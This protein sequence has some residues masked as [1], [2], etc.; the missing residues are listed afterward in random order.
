MNLS[1]FAKLLKKFYYNKNKEKEHIMH[2]SDFFKHFSTLPVMPMTSKYEITVGGAGGL[3]PYLLGI[4]KVI[5]DN[6]A[7]ELSESVIIGTSAGSLLA[8]LLSMGIPVEDYY[9]KL[10]REI[11]YKMKKTYLG[12]TVRVI[13]IF[14]DFFYDDFEA[15]FDPELVH[16]RLYINTTCFLTESSFLINKWESHNHFVDSMVASSLIPGLHT[17]STV[18]LHGRELIDGGF[19]DSFPPVFPH[20]KQVKIDVKQW[21]KFGLS[22]YIP[23]SSVDKWN[24]LYEL[25]KKDA[26][27]NLAEIRRWFHKLKQD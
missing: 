18:T 17:C 8:Y 15:H 1:L 11:T 20:L 7:E 24:E 14:R 13:G 26:M 10:S 6:F 9:K 27:D 2:K 12:S 23:S 16:G 25:G 3:G 5:Q 22:K 19:S 21:R 4:G